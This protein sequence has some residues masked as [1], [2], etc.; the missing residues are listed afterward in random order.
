MSIPLKCGSCGHEEQSEQLAVD[1][2]PPC[3][4]CGNPSLAPAERKPA[5]F[6]VSAADVV[7]PAEPALP[8]LQTFEELGISDRFRQAVEQE[9]TRDE[10]LVW[11]GRPSPNPAVRPPKTVLTVAGAVA[12]GLAVVLLVTG[13]PFIFPVV[14]GLFGLLF[15]VVSRLPNPANAYQACYVVTNR[16]AI[17]FERGILGLDPKAFSLS[18]LLGTRSRSYHPHE[19]LALERRD[20]PRVPGAGDL[21]FEYI[22]TIGR[23]TTGFPGTDSTLQRTDTPQRTPRGFF[24]LEQV[25]E[26]EHLIRKTLLANLEKKLD[27]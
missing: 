17:L 9:L 15:L 13:L 4:A 26:V 19:L 23:T 14:L 10:K 25:A 3:P 24:F 20:N 8:R 18:S 22:F 6:R 5:V 21:I 2:L 11:L 27:Q 12:L 1:N 16:R 7:K